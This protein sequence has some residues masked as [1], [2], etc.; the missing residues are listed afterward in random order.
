M[1]PPLLS[2]VRTAWCR[3]TTSQQ[4]GCT[5]PRLKLQELFTHTKKET[6][7]KDQHQS[8]NEKRRLKTCKLHHRCITSTTGSTGSNGSR[9]QVGFWC[10]CDAVSQHTEAKTATRD[11]RPWNAF[12]LRGNKTK[13]SPMYWIVPQIVKARPPRLS[14]RES[15]KSE[16]RTWPETKHTLR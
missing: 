11:T 14:R 12:Y 8:E 13:I 10:R 7:Q 2:P 15:P 16:R 6:T 5:D 9:A 1:C 3:G 4:R